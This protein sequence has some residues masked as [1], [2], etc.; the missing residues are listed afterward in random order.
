MVGDGPLRS[1]RSEE[2]EESNEASDDARRGEN[3]RHLSEVA[4]REAEQWPKWKKLFSNQA[5]CF[6]LKNS[7]AAIVRFT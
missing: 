4:G 1:A 2:E 3:G 5:F 7:H 6:C